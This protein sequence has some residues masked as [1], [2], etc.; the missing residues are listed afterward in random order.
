MTE[1][2]LSSRNLK[3]Y[4]YKGKPK[5]HFS[6]PIGGICDELQIYSF[7]GL[8]GNLSLVEKKGCLS[9][10]CCLFVFEICSLA[11]KD[12]YRLRVFNNNC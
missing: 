2:D 4:Y 6:V 5:K 7:C 8:S 11:L 1:R 12:G 3:M 10:T 9:L